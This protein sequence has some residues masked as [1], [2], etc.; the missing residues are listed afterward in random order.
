MFQILIAQ[1][2]SIYY[3]KISN[4]Q[5]WLMIYTLFTKLDGQRYSL[6]NITSCITAFLKNDQRTSSDLKNILKKRVALL[7][8]LV[9]VLSKK[10]TKPDIALL[11]CILFH[12]RTANSLLTLIHNFAGESVITASLLQPYLNILE[13]SLPAIIQTKANRREVLPIQQRNHFIQQ[14]TKYGSYAYQYR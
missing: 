7:S 13:I 8:V 4:K 6:Q 1:K 14:S 11:N 3:S 12:Q 9:D 10:R 2:Q 5:D